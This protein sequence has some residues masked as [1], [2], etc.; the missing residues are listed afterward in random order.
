MISQNENWEK[1]R[2]RLL[3]PKKQKKNSEGFVWSCNPVTLELTKV[4]AHKQKAPQTTH[5]PHYE[6]Y[7][8][9]LMPS[10]ARQETKKHRLGRIYA[11]YHPGDVI[12]GP[13]ERGHYGGPNNP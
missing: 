1:I 13:A 11:K 3:N 5:S 7:T 8:R 9:I 12:T 2:T 6:Y 4:P 10:V